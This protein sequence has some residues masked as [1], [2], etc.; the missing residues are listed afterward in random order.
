MKRLELKRLK[1]E[2]LQKRR[3]E[4]K[5]MKR[6]TRVLGKASLNVARQVIGL[7]LESNRDLPNP[8]ITYLDKISGD[9]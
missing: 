8:D 7:E 5:E 6:W 2:T 3:D 4:R 9:K 1:K